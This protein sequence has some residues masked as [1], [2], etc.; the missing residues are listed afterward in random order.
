METRELCLRFLFFLKWT[1]KEI[2]CGERVGPAEG[3]RADCPMMH[4]FPLVLFSLHH[5]RLKLLRSILIS[6][7]F[8]SRHTNQTLAR[9]STQGKGCSAESS[10]KRGLPRNWTPKKAFSSPTFQSH[11]K[12]FFPG[13]LFTLLI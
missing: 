11:K 13:Q 5:H 12:I 8:P 7:Q 9:P 6:M 1:G 10:L 2:G 4:S 3:Q